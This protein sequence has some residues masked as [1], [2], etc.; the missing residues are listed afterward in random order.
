M[1]LKATARFRSF[2]SLLVPGVVM[3][4]FASKKKYRKRF[5]DGFVGKKNDVFLRKPFFWGGKSVFNVFFPPSALKEVLDAT[6]DFYRELVLGPRALGAVTEMG[7]FEGHGLG[8]H[9][10]TN[11]F[12]WFQQCLTCFGG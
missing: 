3:L 8:N 4:F 9:A 10:K 11:V 6:G 2:R 5:R 12:W 1:K 7:S